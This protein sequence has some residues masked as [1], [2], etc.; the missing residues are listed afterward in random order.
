M[1]DV[2]QPRVQQSR[3]KLSSSVPKTRLGLSLAERIK[4]IEARQMG[5]SMRQVRLIIK[6][7]VTIKSNVERQTPFQYSSWLLNLAVVKL[8]FSTH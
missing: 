3:F 6:K 8:K 1:S 5:K 4:V 2:V 7:A